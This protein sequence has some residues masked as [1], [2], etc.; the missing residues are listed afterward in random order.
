MY[1]Q[2]I[3][4]G[5]INEELAVSN[6]ERLLK[7]AGTGI[8]VSFGAIIITIGAFVFGIV[9]I[10]SGIYGIFISDKEYVFPVSI[11]FMLFMYGV[12]LFG[13][14]SFG[15]GCYMIYGLVSEMRKYLS[16]KIH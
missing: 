15:W 14:I 16:R 10:V 8:A 7:K 3:K 12:L 9:S 2:Y 13:I 1:E 5:E 6:A 11:L 4:T